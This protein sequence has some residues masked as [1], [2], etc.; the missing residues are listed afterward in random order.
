MPDKAKGHHDREWRVEAAGRIQSLMVRIDERWDRL[1][2]D[3]REVSTGAAL[4]LWRATF[5]IDDT[6]RT[7]AETNDAARGLLKKMAGSGKTRLLSEDQL[8]RK[9]S[10][11]YYVNNAAVGLVALMRGPY[12]FDDTESLQKAWDK[13]FDGLNDF[14]T[15]ASDPHDASTVRMPNPLNLK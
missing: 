7:V 4:S 10:A 14:I 6:D 5:L 1:L 15:W 13:T 11:G 9:W 2:P 8:F 12:P 3:Q